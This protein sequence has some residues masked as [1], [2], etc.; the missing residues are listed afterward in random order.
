MKT[1]GAIAVAMAFGLGVST[2]TGVFAQGGAH[3]PAPCDNGTLPARFECPTPYVEMDPPASPDEFFR[4]WVCRETGRALGMVQDGSGCGGSTK[5]EMF[6][7]WT[8]PEAVAV[9]GGTLSEEEYRDT[10]IALFKD[11]VR[12]EFDG[13]FLDYERVEQL[14]RGGY[15]FPNTIRGDNPPG[16]WFAQPPG[17]DWLKRV[18]ALEDSGHKFVCFNI[19]SIPSHSGIGYSE[20]CAAQA[21][22]TLWA[23]AGDPNPAAYLDGLVAQFWLATLCHESPQACEPYLPAP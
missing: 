16:G 20:I 11:F 22:S 12:M 14:T 6:P 23:S 1:I 3:V 17:S 2:I 9:A 10:V 7:G 5:D 13:V 18:D 19:P 4:A 21:L 8:V 15:E